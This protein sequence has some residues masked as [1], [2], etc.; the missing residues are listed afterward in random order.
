VR[1][2]GLSL[3]GLNSRIA[4]GLAFS[5]KGDHDSALA[6]FSRCIQLDSRHVFAHVLCGNVH[7][8]LKDNDAARASFN[9]AI[10]M[11]PFAYKA[12]AG[13]ADSHEIEKKWHEA[14]N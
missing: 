2:H 3:V 5:L 13:M 1:T 10:A 12:W 14:D 6:A 9:A 11:D 4:I 7:L 8:E